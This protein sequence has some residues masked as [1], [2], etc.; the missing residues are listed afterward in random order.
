[1]FPIRISNIY[2]RVNSRLAKAKYNFEGCLY[3]S[4]VVSQDPSLSKLS[5]FLQKDQFWQNGGL[6]E[7]RR[8]QRKVLGVVSDYEHCGTLSYPKGLA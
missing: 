3:K 6:E 5:M 1:M 7:V 8:D 4:T 2:S